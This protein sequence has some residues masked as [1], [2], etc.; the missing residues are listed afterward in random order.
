MDLRLPLHLPHQHHSKASAILVS[1][2][3]ELEPRRCLGLPHL[4]KFNFTLTFIYTSKERKLLHHVIKLEIL[5]NGVKTRRLGPLSKLFW[6]DIRA[7][8]TMHIHRRYMTSRS[9]NASLK[10]NNWRK[11]AYFYTPAIIYPYFLQKAR[12][13]TK[14]YTTGVVPSFSPAFQKIFTCHYF[15]LF[16]PK[17]IVELNV[18]MTC[19]IP[20]KTHV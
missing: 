4:W 5:F 13:L 19:G 15:I 1:D 20:P 16:M 8:Y 3:G 10:S 11:H 18:L 2:D 14:N 12:K 7:F 17:W 6:Q 9:S